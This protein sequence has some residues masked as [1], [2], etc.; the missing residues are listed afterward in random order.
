MAIV[1]DR[2]APQRLKLELFTI[3]LAIPFGIFALASFAWLVLKRRSQRQA[4][5]LALLRERHIDFFKK[6][7]ADFGSLVESSRANEQSL[8]R[9]SK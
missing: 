8:L 2:A 9:N 6:V 5:A 1:L 4:R 3:V 7:K